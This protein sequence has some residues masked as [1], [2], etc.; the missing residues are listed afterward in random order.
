MYKYSLLSLILEQDFSFSHFS[1]K[2][3]HHFSFFTTKLLK[4]IC[5]YIF[6]YFFLSPFHTPLPPPTPW[7]W[8]WQD[9]QHSKPN[10][11]VSVLT[12]LDPLSAFDTIEHCPPF[13]EPFSPFLWSFSSF[14]DHHSV[15]IAV[16][17]QLSNL[18]NFGA[19]AQ[20][21]ELFSLLPVL[22]P[23]MTS[24]NLMVL[25]IT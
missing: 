8:S 6:S 21:L 16:F 23:W 19:R 14:A 18:L 13:F 2:P 15:S 20:S 10:G 12:F 9:H 3:S 4:K 25:K 5:L 1:L 22:S 7:N 24:S 17:N 11:H